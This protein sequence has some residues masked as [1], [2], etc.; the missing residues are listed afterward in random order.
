[1]HARQRGLQHPWSAR[2]TPCG[3]AGCR[4]SWWCAATRRTGPRCRARPRPR[5]GDRRAGLSAASA[6]CAALVLFLYSDILFEVDRARTKPLR[7]E[8]DCAIVVD[9]AGGPARAAAAAREAARPGG[10][11]PH[12]RGLACRPRPWRSPPTT[13]WSRSA[14]ASP[15]SGP[16]ASSSASFSERDRPRREANARPMAAGTGPFHEAD[17]ETAPSTSPEELVQREDGGGPPGEGRPRGRARSRTTSGRGD[18]GQPASPGCRKP[19]R[20]IFTG[21]PAPCIEAHPG[22]DTLRS[23]ERR[24]GTWRWGLAAWPRSPADG[25]VVTGPWHEH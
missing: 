8:T 18:Q 7:A 14:S 21:V 6:S 5:P 24:R 13:G 22:L 10:D 12:A 16:P 19:R 15:P 25:D 17:G 9:R 2:S 20:M 23:P 1:M 3:P 4:T 11:R